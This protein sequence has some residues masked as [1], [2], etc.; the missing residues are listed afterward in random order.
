MLNTA[1]IGTIVKF[2][3]IRGGM[4]GWAGRQ[5]VAL[6]QNNVAPT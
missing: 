2:M 6:Q 4:P 5:F 3:N 1:D